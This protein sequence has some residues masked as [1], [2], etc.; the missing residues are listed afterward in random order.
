MRKYTIPRSCAPTRV[1]GLTSGYGVTEFAGKSVGKVSA[2]HCS[3][4]GAGIIGKVARPFGRRGDEDA[5]RIY[6][7]RLPGALVINEE[8]E[9]VAHDR[10]AQNATEL[11][12]VEHATD[13]RKVVPGIEPVITQELE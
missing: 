10:P 12:L 7:N 5:T 2:I 4:Q 1:I 8:E 6:A 11:V 3:G 13:R 9:L